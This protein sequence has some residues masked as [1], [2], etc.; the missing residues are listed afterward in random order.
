MIRY[1]P[2]NQF[3]NKI[4]SIII[5]FK[6]SITDKFYLHIAHLGFFQTHKSGLVSV[7]IQ[8]YNRVDILFDRAIQSILKQTYQ[9][10][11]IIIIDDGSVDGTYN[12]IIEFNHPKIKV[13]KNSRKKYR[14]PNKAIYHWFAGPVSALNFGLK[15]CNG[16]YI[17]RIDDDDIWTDDHLSKLV[18]FLEKNKYEFVYSHL[19]VKMSISEDESI[20]TNEPDPLGNTCTWLYKSYLKKF[21]INIHCWRKTKNRVNDVDVHD[22]FFKAGVKIGYLNEVT[23][24]YLPR[25]NEHY[26]GS[27]AYINNSDLVESTYS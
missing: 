11:E 14:Y 19:K 7:L 9:N 23:S 6:F 20:I 3:F 25:P 2:D 27:K 8:T 12:R 16:Q 15:F 4:I 5:G 17:A 1:L 21:K 26:S 10:Y 22:R 18:S 13:Y 24:I